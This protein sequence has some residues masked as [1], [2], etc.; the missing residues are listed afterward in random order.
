MDEEEKAI[1]TLRK[2][3]K[4]LDKH[5][6]EYWLDEGALLGT[7]R[8][9]KL[10]EWD[11]DIDLSVWYTTLPKIAPLFN[12]I[13]NAGCEVCF[14]EDK[15]HIKLIDKGYEIDINLYHL[16]NNKATRTWYEHN[17]LGRVLDYI[18]WTIYIRN[19]GSRKSNAPLF[20]TKILVSISNVL[21]DRSN[22]KIL[23]LIFKLYKKK[24][25]RLVQMSVP[26]H[27]FT[28]LSTLD[29]YGMKIKVPKK[30]EEY[31]ELRYGKNWRIPKRDYIYTK[32][33]CS[34]VKDQK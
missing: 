12:E 13:R 33:D 8:D 19:A 6:I 29:F 22:K 3:K 34:I 16:K 7:V 23:G 20:L 28:D 18:M 24:G 31:L 1:E 2:I 25:C 11:N 27:F 26:S 14:F 4:I 10:I 17:K 5:N 9:K 21:S 32:D 30:T 15:K